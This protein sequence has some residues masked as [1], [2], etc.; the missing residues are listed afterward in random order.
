MASYGRRTAQETLEQLAAHARTGG[1]DFVQG[2]V[3]GYQ[4]ALARIG[5]EPVGGMAQ[6]GRVSF[7]P[8][9]ARPTEVQVDTSVYRGYHGAEP[10]GR[11]NWTFVIGK[12]RQEFSDEPALYRPADQHGVSTL[13]YSKAVKYAV[14]E[15]KRRGASVVGIAP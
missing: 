11:A 15:A 12:I 14:A 8:L 1:G 4:D 3:A 6:Q 10:R 5:R 13:P 9:A 7:V 2:Q